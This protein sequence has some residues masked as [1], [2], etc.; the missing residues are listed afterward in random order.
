[1]QTLLIQS[2]SATK[3]ETQ[4]KI[5]AIDLYEGYFFKIIKK[6]KR[7]LGIRSDM[8]IMI[9]SA[10][11]GLIEPDKEIS[12]YD[13]RM[14]ENKARKLNKEVLDD[15]KQKLTQKKYDKIVCNTGNNYREALAGI[16]DVI[17]PEQEL[18]VI[19]GSGIGEKGRILKKLISSSSL[20]QFAN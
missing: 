16:E 14:D 1:M 3:K 19:E 5:P 10:K 11:H 20:K 7:D 15:L 13:V 2:C 4:Q 6:A 18:E 17:G 9:I 8:D 12:Y